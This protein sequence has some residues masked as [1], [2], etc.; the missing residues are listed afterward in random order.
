M[1]LPAS[2]LSQVCRSI[3]DFVSNRLEAAQRNIQVRI[4]SPASAAP[5][6]NDTD[7]R[8]NLFFYRIE[9]NGFGP[10]AAPDETWLLRLSCLVTTF[11]VEEDQISAGENDLR[12]LGGVLS[13]FHE[14]PILDPVAINGTTVRPQVVFQ[15]LGMEDI[16]HLWAT[17]G[18]VAYRPSVAYEMALV[19]VPPRT[20]RIGGPMVG[21]VSFE[22]RSGVEHSG[23]PFA[24][25]ELLP[26]PVIA[27]EVDTRRED[28]AP[29]I[30]FVASG[31]CVESVSFAVGSPELAAFAPR[32]WVAGI[33]GAAVRLRW[34]I[35]DAQTGWRP[36]GT[37]VNTTA[38][39]PLLD[40][41]QP[42]GATTVAVTLPF[43]DH[44]GQS[45]L[46]AERTFNRAV[47]GVQ[48]TVRSNPLLV[49]LF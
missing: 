41:D 14:R 40:P 18:E 17:Q 32:V 6:Q 10:A 13:A 42:A 37:D 19:P 16:N 26:P 29:R 11:G 45:A 31:A 30:C 39:G 15:P 7:H 46:Y 1:A 24:G 21:G 43:D 25:Q 3:A 35:W 22:V 4:G 8:V 27:R 2:S 5:A 49:N 33:D 36:G 28:W 47:D 38:T 34:E 44:A 12:L 23:A 20:P 48:I 9:P